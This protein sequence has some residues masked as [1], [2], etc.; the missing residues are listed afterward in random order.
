MAGQN[1]ASDVY[2]RQA[3]CLLTYLQTRTP[4]QMLLVGA[5]I[6][7]NS[8]VVEVVCLKLPRAGMSRTQKLG[9]HS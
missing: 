1:N 3:P 8:L 4:F 2:K 9:S 7:W 6:N 5:V